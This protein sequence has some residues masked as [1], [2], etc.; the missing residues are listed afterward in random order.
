MAICCLLSVVGSQSGKSDPAGGGF[1]EDE[2]CKPESQ[3]DIYKAVSR[4]SG[5]GRKHFREA[6]SANHLVQKQG[7]SQQPSVIKQCQELWG[8]QNPRVWR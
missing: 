1:P 5:S 4:G 6:S 8:G 7:D 3:V 2:T